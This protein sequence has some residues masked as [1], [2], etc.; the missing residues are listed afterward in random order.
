LRDSMKAKASRIKELKDLL[1][2]AES[3]RQLKPL[4]DEMNAIKWK[5]KRQKFKETHERELRLLYVAQ[6]KLKA[7]SDAE[8]R[9]SESAWKQEIAKLEHERKAEYERFKTLREN[10]MELLKVKHCVD[11]AANQQEQEQRRQL[12]QNQEYYQ[13]L[14]NQ[15]QAETR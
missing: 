12:Q 3:Y 1:Q 4:L 11:V 13:R 9:Y 7:A 10:L 6:R 5:G 8:G 14:Q 15:Q 2:Y